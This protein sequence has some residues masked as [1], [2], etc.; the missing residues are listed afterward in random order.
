MTHRTLLRTS[1]FPLALATLAA[2][3][4]AQDEQAELVKLR[5][6]KLQAEFLTKAPWQLDF[7]KAQAAAQGEQKLIFGYFTRSYAPAAPRV[8]KPSSR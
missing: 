5:A 2:L 4:N 1:L 3:L 7:S 6:K 8:S